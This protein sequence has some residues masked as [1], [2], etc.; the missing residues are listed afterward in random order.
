MEGITDQLTILNSLKIAGECSEN[1]LTLKNM[2]DNISMRPDIEI[3]KAL[4]SIVK[5]RQKCLDQVSAYELTCSKRLM[6]LMRVAPLM[7]CMV[8]LNWS[9]E[10]GDVM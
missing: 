8:V 2:V 10:R 9:L 6:F 5:H 7:R 1:T 4:I 3:S